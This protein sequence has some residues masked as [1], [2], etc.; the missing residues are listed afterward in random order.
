M[1]CYILTETI[2]YKNHFSRRV[3][4]SGKRNLNENEILIIFDNGV[5]LKSPSD[6]QNNIHYHTTKDNQRHNPHWRETTKH[7]LNNQKLK[8]SVYE[9]ISPATSYSVWSAYL[10]SSKP[11]NNNRKWSIHNVLS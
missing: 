8:K 2:V 9:P 3:K 6:K 11:N 7:Q 4:I 1:V 5:N 10:A